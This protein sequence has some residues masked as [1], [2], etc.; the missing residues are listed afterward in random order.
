MLFDDP[1]GWDGI[2]G[3]LLRG[4]VCVYIKLIHFIVQ[5]KQIQHCNT[6]ILQFKD[7]EKIKQKHLLWSSYEGYNG[8]TE[9]GTVLDSVNQS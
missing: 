4:G 8:Y 6:I 5:Q 1:E 9:F 7:K 3:G 2:E